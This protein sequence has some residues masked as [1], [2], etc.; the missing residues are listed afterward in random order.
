VISDLR[1]SFKTL[2]TWNPVF[3]SLPIAAPTHQH[4]KTSMLRVE[5]LGECWELDNI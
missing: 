5:Y 2:D 3:C 4:Y 1:S